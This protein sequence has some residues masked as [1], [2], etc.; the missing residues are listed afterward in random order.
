MKEF[1][2]NLNDHD[3]HHCIDAMNNI[4]NRMC[5]LYEEAKATEKQR[6]IDDNE[7][8]QK[9]PTAY[10]TKI[11]QEIERKLTQVIIQECSKS[12]TPAKFIQVFIEKMKNK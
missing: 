10:R 7:E 2:N 4:Y 1:L 5:Q 11:H 12:K 3:F 6:W 9:N 8:R